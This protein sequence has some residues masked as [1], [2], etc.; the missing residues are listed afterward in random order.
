MAFP[1]VA[2][3]ASETSRAPG[4]V[5]SAAM[6]TSFLLPSSMQMARPIP[7]ATPVT[8]VLLSP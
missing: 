2:L 6:T 5:L 4:S 1:P 3:M 7:E 8:S